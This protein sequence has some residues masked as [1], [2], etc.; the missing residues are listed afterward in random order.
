MHQRDEVEYKRE[1]H[2]I[3]R[4]AW[5]RW[6]G[7]EF[8]SMTLKASSLLLCVYRH[9]NCNPFRGGGRGTQAPQKDEWMKFW[10]ARRWQDVILIIQCDWQCRRLALEP[11]LWTCTTYYNTVRGCK[12]CFLHHNSQLD[13]LKNQAMLSQHSEWVVARQDVC[14]HRGTGGDD[15][16]N[17][18]WIQEEFT[19]YR[20][21]KTRPNAGG[22]TWLT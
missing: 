8:T 19:G 1:R 15:C 6:M 11:R 18:G 16:Y 4:K 7:G 2:V 3:V 10:P 22:E 21:L 9:W 13:V 5:W 14:I 17:T 12:A 20:K